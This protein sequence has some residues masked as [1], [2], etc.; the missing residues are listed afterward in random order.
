M[1][2][3]KLRE[4]VPAKPWVPVGIDVVGDTALR[5]ARIEGE[6][7]WHR[8][9]EEEEFFLVVSGVVIIETETERVELGEWEGCKVP[10]G[11]LHRSRSPNGAV[12]L[13][14]EPATTKT[15]GED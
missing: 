8:H 12:V 11:T 3:I 7:Q 9:D 15:C 1:E 5:V 10:A 14:I 2:K 13:M 6:Y 4:L